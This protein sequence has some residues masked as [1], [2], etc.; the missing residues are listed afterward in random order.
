MTYPSSASLARGASLTL[1]IL[2]ASAPS[3]LASPPLTRALDYDAP[4]ECPTRQAFERFVD[5]IDT[6]SRETP[7]FTRRVT[8]V[9]THETSFEG[10]LVVQ[11]ANGLEDARTFAGPQCEVV[12][13]ALALSTA[14]ALERVP[15][16]P[17]ALVTR[18][19]PAPQRDSQG[20]EDRDANG[21]AVQALGAAGGDGL[22]RTLVGLR[23]KVSLLSLGGTHIGADLGAGTLDVTRTS[24]PSVGT[25]RGDAELIGGSL[26]WGAPWNDAVFGAS[27]DAGILRERLQGQLSST[28]CKAGV[29]F[30]D[31]SSYVPTDLSVV[32]GYASFAVTE[33]LPIR[34]FFLRPF[35]QEG[36]LLAFEQAGSPAFLFTLSGGVAIRGW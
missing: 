16:S 10:R 27:L 33:Q 17:P 19:W 8:I 15:P 31:G 24:G 1:I 25:L 6:A 5:E 20:T 12:L 3:A 32:T 2:A 13:R 34:R 9:V 29:C 35:I 18:H 30:V 11:R 28:S 4:P 36:G 7:D 23:G 14:F 26:M 21:V 22:G